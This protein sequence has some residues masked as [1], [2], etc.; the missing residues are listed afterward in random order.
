MLLACTLAGCR[1]GD[2]RPWVICDRIYEQCREKVPPLSQRECE[3]E[4]KSAP[5]Q[6][7]DH[8]LL[9]TRERECPGIGVECFKAVTG[10]PK[11]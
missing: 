9:C 1:K 4:L 11:R 7:L 2:R 8:L 5:P 10:G 6:V 3:A